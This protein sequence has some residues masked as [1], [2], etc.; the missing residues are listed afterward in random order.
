M[1]TTVSAHTV[2]EEVAGLVQAVRHE[3]AGEFAA[4]AVHASGLL[5]SGH[6]DQRDPAFMITVDGRQFVVQVQEVG[7]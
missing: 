1:A 3:L 4:E 7:R 5:R 2:A 6:R